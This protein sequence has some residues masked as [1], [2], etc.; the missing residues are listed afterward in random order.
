VL[1]SRLLPAAVPP[2]AWRSA[3]PDGTRIVLVAGAHSETMA[4]LDMLRAPLPPEEWRPDLDAW[5]QKL[6]LYFAADGE[7]HGGVPPGELP[8]IMAS[9]DASTAGDAPTAG[10]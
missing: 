2:G 10:L 9:G 3:E 1:T 4:V 5:Q 6:K 8:G 7:L